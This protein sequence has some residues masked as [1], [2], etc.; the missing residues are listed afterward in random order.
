MLAL[1][2]WTLDVGILAP[3]RPRD[4]LCW[5]VPRGASDTLS[6]DRPSDTIRFPRPQPRRGRFGLLLLVV[7]AGFFL[8]GGG[9]VLSYYVEALWF[10]SLGYGDV[11]WKTL[12]LRSGLFVAVGGDHVRRVVRGL[13]GAEAGR[14][15]GELGT[16]GIIMINDRPVKLPVGPVLAMIAALMS[17]LVALG[18]AAGIARSGRRSRLWWYGSG[19]AAPR[20]GR[21]PCRRPDLRPPARVL[22]VHAAG[23]AAGVRLGAAPRVPDLR[24]GAVLL[25]RLERQPHGARRPRRGRGRCARCAGLALAW[26]FLLL[27]IAAQVWLGRFERCS[28]ITPSLPA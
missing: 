14:Q 7:A 4:R 24:D 8:F 19:V 27:A 1:A 5:A 16:D 18:S 2:R 10:A 23:L 11:F 21:R 28:T 12:Q 6:N 13:P 3:C 25:R 15:F 20:G 9:A 22:P 17:A 26:G